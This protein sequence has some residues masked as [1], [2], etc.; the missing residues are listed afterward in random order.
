[1]EE[2]KECLV[3]YRIWY[4]PFNRSSGPGY[5]YRGDQPNFGFYKS[6]EMA[7]KQTDWMKEYD[8]VKIHRF[9]IKREEID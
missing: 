6:I 3:R 5:Y 8:E 7:E 9:I 2:N 4:R 1:M